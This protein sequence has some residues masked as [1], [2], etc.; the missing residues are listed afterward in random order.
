MLVQAESIFDW[1]IIIALGI[2]PWIVWLC[3][4]FGLIHMRDK[5]R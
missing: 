4:I 3:L 5:D 2:G 1:I